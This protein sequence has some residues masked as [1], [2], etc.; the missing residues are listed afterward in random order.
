MRFELAG[1]GGNCSTCSWIAAEGVIESD[2]AQQLEAYLKS[3]R[4]TYQPTIAFHSPGGDL[5]GG[6][7]LGELIRRRGFDTAVMQT[8]FGVS[9]AVDPYDNEAPGTCAS[10]CAYAF[11]GGTERRV[12]E[13]SRVGVHQFASRGAASEAATQSTT[14][15]LAAY[16]A[17]MGVSRDLILP[18]GFALPEEMYWLTRSDLE[19]LNVVTDRAEVAEVDWEIKESGGELS[20]IAQQ[21]RADGKR[22]TLLLQCAPQRTEYVFVWAVDVGE[23]YQSLAASVAASITGFT[24]TVGDEF[25]RPLLGKASADDSLIMV[26]AIVPNALMQTYA[27]AVEPIGL[28]MDMPHAVASYVGWGQTVPRK[29]LA[30]LLPILDRNC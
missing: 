20:L 29:N 14:A 15:A 5:A 24:F 17:R 13:G 30:R 28:S 10:A 27:R 18:A 11:L 1:N 26:G 16:M 4:I 22:G 19:R 12:P 2:T 25:Q 21:G 6:L 9:G 3:E 7:K 23:Q 8:V